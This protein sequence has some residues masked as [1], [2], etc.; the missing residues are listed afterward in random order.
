V[1]A[2]DLLGSTHGAAQFL[3]AAQFLDIRLPTHRLD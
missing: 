3:A 1:V 2:L